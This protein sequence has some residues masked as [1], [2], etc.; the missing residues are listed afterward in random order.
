MTKGPISAGRQL[1]RAFGFLSG[2]AG[3]RAP[4]E[5]IFLKRDA[6]PGGFR[7]FGERS[8]TQEGSTQE[9]PRNIG[10]FWLRGTSVPDAGPE[11]SKDQRTFGWRSRVGQSGSS[12]E[13]AV[14]WDATPELV[15]QDRE[16]IGGLRVF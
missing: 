12:H 6:V 11:G 2:P 8:G 5:S 10:R 13:G 7:I 4:E 14:R 15:S 3:K 1:R 9:G 16:R